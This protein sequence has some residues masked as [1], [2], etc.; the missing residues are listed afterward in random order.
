MKWVMKYL[1]LFC[2]FI[3]IS[4]NAR[5]SNGYLDIARLGYEQYQ[6]IFIN[7]SVVQHATHHHAD[8]DIRYQII[9]AFLRN[10]HRAFTMLDL[11]ASQGYYSFRAASEYP[12]SVFV[13]IE[14]NNKYYPLVGSQ[15]LDLCKANTALHNIIFLNKEIKIEDVRRLSEC[16]HIDVVL[17]LNV[18]H[19]FGQSW[20][21]ITD[22]IL[23]MGS[24]VIV[25]TPP[26]ET[27]VSTESNRLRHAI[28]EYLMS[29]GAQV[30]G[31]V[32]RHTSNTVA[33]MYLLSPQKNILERK[34]WL[35]PLL[36]EKTHL[37]EADFN[38][39][40][41][42]KKVN[43]TV[44]TWHTNDWAPGINLLTFKMY[45]GAYPTA[46]RLKKMISDVRDFTHNDWVMTNMI[47]QGDKMHLIDFNDP[48]HNPGGRGGGNFAC[49][50]TYFENHL[51]L[52]EITDPV[53]VE[54]FFLSN[55]V[56]LPHKYGSPSR[57]VKSLVDKNDLV[58]YI[59]ATEWDAIQGH[60]LH[61][62][63]V[64]MINAG[65]DCV[66]GHCRAHAHQQIMVDKYITS[67]KEHQ[68]TEI[69]M[70]ELTDTYGVPRYCVF[71]GK[72]S[73][74]IVQQLQCP[75][76]CVSFPFATHSIESTVNSVRHLASLGYQ[77]FNFSCGQVPLFTVAK[78]QGPSDVVD[79]INEC[80]QNDRTEHE[81]SGYVYACV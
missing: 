7:G 60:V 47:V 61:D 5:A 26:Q 53:E 29:K 79:C 56:K 57:F 46:E 62:A 52:M 25:E 2:T 71:T 17:A 36:K 6:D 33:T 11:G 1:F 30:I 27:V 51:K 58:F 15:L 68:E 80:A 40:K 24:Y 42:H 4:Y 32:P 59:G 19:W 74:Q 67:Q 21:D 75:I 16:E 78:W 18:I 38:Q 50:Q 22:I 69:T 41:I 70:Q 76:G 31:H 73:D 66:G 37:I 35:T 54:R 63:K 77:S 72:Q 49:L 23:N 10:Y 20:K 45:Q 39:K 3:T 9:D 43:R 34:T 13:M 55:L 12:D 14:G 48:V 81:L 64:V 44:D 65:S 28:E 8:C